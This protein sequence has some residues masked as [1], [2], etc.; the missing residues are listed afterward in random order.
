M[1][2]YEAYNVVLTDLEGNELYNEETTEQQMQLPVED[3][4]EGQLYLFR[5]AN[6]Y[7]SGLTDYTEY[8]WTYVPC[9]EYA[10]AE[11][12]VYTVMD[13]GNM[14]TWDNP[15]GGGQIEILLYDTYGDGWNGG[16]LTVTFGNGDVETLT[17]D[18]GWSTSFAYDLNSQHITMVYTPGSWSG[19]NYFEVKTDDGEVLAYAEPNTMY[20]G[21]TVEFDVVNKAKT[22][23]VRDGESLGFIDDNYYFDEGDT[24]E[25]EYVIRIVYPDYAMACEQVAEYKELFQITATANAGGL[26]NGDVMYS[27]IM[28]EGT[29]CTLEAMPYEGY[30]FK[31]WTK[32][33]EAVSTD[34]IY[35]FVVEEDADYVAN[36]VDMSNFYIVDPNAYES[37]MTLT[38][39]VKID[40]VEQDNRFLEVSAWSGDEVRGTAFLEH[41]DITIGE[42]TIDRYFVLMTVYGN[43]GDELTF[44]LYDHNTAEELDIMCT[45]NLTFEA[46]ENYGSLTD[47]YV[48]N[49]MN[50]IAVDYQ[51]TPGWNWWSTHVE[52]TAIDGMAMLEEGVGENASQISSQSSFT[53]YYAGYGW[54]GSLTAINNESMYRVQ[55]TDEVEFSMVGPKADPADHPIT[56]V[57]G[58]NHIGYVSGAEMSVNDALANITAQQGDMVKSQ[59]SYANYY[60]GYGWY[61]SLNTIKPG[62]GLMFKSVNDNPVTFTY[63]VAVAGAKDLAENLTGDNN[64][65]VPNVYAY[66]SNMTVMAI[67]EME[68]VEL[69][70]DNYEVAAFVNGE[71]RGSIQLVYAE[72][73]NRFVAFLTVSGEEVANMYFGLYNKETGEEF[74]NTN[75]SLTFNADAMVGDPDE[76]FVIGFRDSSAINELGN[77]MTLYPNPASIGEKVNVL[78]PNSMRPVRIEIVDAIGK[79]VSVESST[80]WPAS[81]AVPA[82]AGVYTVRIITEDNGVMIQKMVVK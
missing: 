29:N 76:P 47:P 81:I 61:G 77:A 30:V 34:A 38:G 57:K 73:L 9:E 80:N 71:C 5:V 25:H 75:T 28:F 53:N 60:E 26:V 4:V 74:F 55:M 72:P 11:S 18:D 64:H 48:I 70:S 20:S 21:M 82:S 3:L 52:L 41:V 17:L 15:V 12:V 6:K 19:E 27:E 68:G 44:K 2:H 54:Y 32:D 31:N 37:N 50:V 62:D 23:F 45:S 39:I 66:P 10:G 65:W 56:L 79:I 78:I 58:W 63:P 16:Y 24:D 22:L 43:Q 36:F 67:V 13:G 35:T 69:A 14:V 46:D 40:G 7:T 59:K 49:F 51:F 1:R 8:Y 42:N 33:G